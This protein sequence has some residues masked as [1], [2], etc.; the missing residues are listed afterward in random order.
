M[1]GEV[2]RAPPGLVVRTGAI[3]GAMGYLGEGLIE[4]FNDA[5]PDAQ[6]LVVCEST[7][8]EVLRRLQEGEC[9]IAVL[10]ETPGDSI[11]SME[12]V[13]DSYFLWVS[14][15]NA[16]SHC[17]CLSLDDLSGQ[18]LAIFDLEPDLT[19]PFVLAIR[20]SGVAANLRFVGEIMRV[21]ELAHENRAVGLTCRNHVEAT[22]GTDV[23]G[24]PFDIFDMTYH[25]C[26]RAETE[27]PEAVQVFVRFM[28]GKRMIYGKRRG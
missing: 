17:T 19:D 26:W 11:R 27:M 13:R 12:L 24:I 7:N 21:F 22:R 6:A 20:K 10:A 9:D 25:L 8:A 15:K 18:T 5:C 14:E 4:E 3:M 16:L 23:V 28:E 2:G 1:Q